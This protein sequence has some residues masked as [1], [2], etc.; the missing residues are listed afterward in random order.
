MRI[1]LPKNGTFIGHDETLFFL[2]GPIKG[3]GDWQWKCC[4][5]LNELV[6]KLGGKPLIAV[7]CR[8]G[9]SHPAWMF[10]SEHDLLYPFGPFLRQLTWER[11]CMDLASKSGCLIFWLPEESRSRPRDDGQP[12][13]RDTYGEIG[14]WRGR[15]MGRIGNVGGQNLKV[16]W[17]AEPGFPGLDVIERNFELALNF[18]FPRY[19]T[20]EATVEAAI[21]I[22]TK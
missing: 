3:G 21:A 7:P 15:M 10:R 22:A 11:H 5:I 18:N 20:L 1:I 19:S 13:A 14:E 16:V 9:D 4:L 6:T 2:A 8:W 17:G 12:Y